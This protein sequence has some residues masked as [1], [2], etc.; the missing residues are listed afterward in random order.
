MR[1]VVALLAL[2]VSI[3]ACTE[4]PT[5][6]EE[7]AAPQ[8]ARVSPADRPGFVEMVTWVYDG[9]QIRNFPCVGDMQLWGD[10][11]V[12]G[13]STPTGWGG[14]NIIVD[15]VYQPSFH[16]VE[17]ATGDVWYPTSTAQPVRFQ[18]KR[19]G[20]AWRAGGELL[21]DFVREDGARSFKIR[22]HFWLEVGPGWDGTG[23]ALPFVDFST[24]EF[25]TTACVVH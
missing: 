11:T 1:T 18:L 13:K 9:T 7:S 8:L 10:Q 19:D 20:T 21:E 14:L 16:L 17:V 4:Q 25:K 22:T 23:D 6:L 15:H 12:Y 5:A 3:T 24:Y 2:A